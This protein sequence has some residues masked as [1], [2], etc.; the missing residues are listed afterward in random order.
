[1]LFEKI[2][3]ICGI[4]CPSIS[5][6]DTVSQFNVPHTHNELIRKIVTFECKKLLLLKSPQNKVA[7]TLEKK[8]SQT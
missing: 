1:M 8:T 5:I 3:F 2:A 7:S 6:C 4:Y